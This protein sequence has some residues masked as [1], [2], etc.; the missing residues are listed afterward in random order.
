MVAN[1][2][3]VGADLVELRRRHPP[4]LGGATLK[5][6][7]AVCDDL[8]LSTRAVTCRVSE[9]R[10]LRTPCLLHWRFNHFVVLKS[11][12]RDHLVIH[13][14]ARGVVRD[15]FERAM[16]AFTGVALEVSR[17]SGFRKSRPPPKLRLSG[18]LPLEAGIGRKLSA[19][20]VLALICEML[21][22]ASPFYLQA[23]IDQ[24]LG[25]GDYLLLNTLAVGFGVLLLFQVIA[26]T[27]RQLTF[28]YL[29]QVSVFDITARVL[30]KLL[31][32]PLTYFRNRDL[33]DVQH[34]VQSLRRVQNFIVHSAPA[35]VLDVLF[36]ILIM[37]LM[38]VYEPH[39]TILAIAATLTWCLWR[40]MMFPLRLR[41][42]SDIA[43]SE[44]SL[45]T[46]FLETLRAVQTIKMT[47]GEAAR[48]SE[49]RDLFANGINEKIRAGNLVILDGALR[50]MLFQ[51]VRVVA[52]YILAKRGLNGQM[53]IGMVSAFVAY[54][55]MFITRANGIVDRVI[56][57]KLLEVPLNRLADIVFNDE[58]PAGHGKSTRAASAHEI[59]LKEVA[60]SYAPSEPWILKSC[61]CRIAESSFIA[62]AG[63]S[64]M[65]KS[66]LLRL[67]AGVEALSVGRILVGGTEI[68]DW[69]LHSL[70]EEMA[71]VFQD[72][73]LLRGSIAE[74]IAVFE[75]SIDL[76][77]VRRAAQDACIDTEI[78]SLSMGY[79]TRI[80]DLGSTLSK[81]QVQR[82][83]LARAFYRKPKLLLLDEA[84]SGLDVQLE[85]RV[86]D[87][88]SR[89]DMTRVV[90]THSD[91][92]LQAA[93]EVMWLHR[94]TLLSSR[95]ELNV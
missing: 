69:H 44:S 42:S 17:G 37:G 20:L 86:I 95:P 93:H 53:S 84:T 34:R 76:G 16:D 81:G 33:G 3:G 54:L 23:V 64:G 94:G 39:L 21:V 63:C 1:Y 9:L 47:N 40:A 30:H 32:L 66:T 26:N 5:S 12:G 38:T 2:L 46:H 4:S 18:L 67:I 73:C 22:L 57:Y 82:I 71:T 79:E 8:R 28:Q 51:G 36:V 77:R 65:G 89:L 31:R 7:T 15:S 70:R 50:Q 29:S 25:K 43:T 58:E 85:K 49:W 45:Q 6:I 72:D 90:I 62:I 10:S 56:E 60:F 87:T 88:I 24:V 19:G 68:S 80:C 59:E 61:S 78:E 11:V 55:G 75:R 52:I 91:Q 83:L 41:L 27:M 48:Q 14:P 35:L 74:N 92:M 13:D